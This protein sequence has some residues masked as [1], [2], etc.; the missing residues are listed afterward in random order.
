MKGPHEMKEK[1]Q[2]DWDTQ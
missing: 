2:R 1:L